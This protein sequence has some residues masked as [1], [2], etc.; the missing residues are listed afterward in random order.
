M[1]NKIMPIKKKEVQFSDKTDI[2]LGFEIECFVRDREYS[3]FCNEVRANDTEVG[4]D[5]SIN[6]NYTKNRSAELR[7][8]PLP[9]KKAMKLLKKLFVIVDEHG[10]T[11]ASCGLHVNI[12]S[13]KKNKMIKFN[14]IPFYNSSIWDNILHTFKRGNNY[15][16]KRLNLNSK[17]QPYAVWFKN[18]TN[19][20]DDRYRCINLNNFGNKISRNSRVEIRGMGN[21]H[22][23][24][25]YPVV[26]T[27]V[28][29]ITNLFNKSCKC[30]LKIPE[31]KV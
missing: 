12:S 24:K 17:S 6:V 28:K 23:Q 2:R 1:L 11:N 21:R 8:K 5:G 3:T 22:Y 19:L 31:Y 7:T 4:D 16:C 15:Y 30:S 20:L 25:K 13:A 27:Y 14:P 26:A 10:G 9:P 18:F 29:K